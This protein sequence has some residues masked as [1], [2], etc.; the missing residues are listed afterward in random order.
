M[1]AAKACLP[2]PD[3]EGLGD[4]GSV[5]SRG[6]STEEVSAAMR[7]FLP[8][9][10]RCTPEGEVLEGTVVAELRVGCD[11]RVARVD[12]ADGGGLPDPVVACVKDTLRYAPFPAHDVPDGFAFEFPLTFSR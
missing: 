2:P 10:L 9:T 7:A 5:S 4:A 8:T 11:G 12:I 6:L 1:P 3:G